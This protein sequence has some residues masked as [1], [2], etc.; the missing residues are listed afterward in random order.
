M[1]EVEAPGPAKAW[2]DEPKPF[3]FISYRRIDTRR[4]TRELLD[5]IEYEFGPN[6]A[7][8][9]IDSIRFG[10]DWQDRIHDSL[11]RC[12]ILIAVIG[13]RWLSSTDEYHRRR[14]DN[15]DDWVRKEIEHALNSGTPII[16]IIVAGEQPP[17]E[18]ALPESISRL[19][20]LQ[21]LTLRPDDWDTDLDNLYRCMENLGFRRSRSKVNYPQPT[22]MEPPAT[23]AEIDQFLKRHTGWEIQY[24]PDPQVP[25]KKRRGIGTSLDFAAFRDAIHF[26]SSA[27]W[28]ID[29]RN[30]HPEWENIWKTVI[31]WITQF[32]IGGNVTARN[33]ELAEYLMEAYEPYRKS[34][35]GTPRPR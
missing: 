25:G 8:V 11:R 22:I 24:R 31:I 3:A 33:L 5:S 21:A 18:A 27:S 32:D 34:L 30:H 26:M 23:E 15:E 20:S 12:D 10:E 7:F 14:I 2:A 1:H 19:A 6:S 13:D 35:P 29:Q 9:D 16:P 17:A 28:G 4:E